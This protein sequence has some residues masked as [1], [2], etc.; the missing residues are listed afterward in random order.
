M[1][2]TVALAVALGVVLGGCTVEPPD[3]DPTA[4][5]EARLDELR[6]DPFVDPGD[7][8]LAGPQLGSNG[9]Y[10]GG[11]ARARRTAQEPM[12]EVVTAELAAAAQAGWSPY[13]A[14]CDDDV[15]DSVGAGKVTV[16][17]VRELAD[18]ALADGWL[19]VSGD[20]AGASVLLDA[21]VPHH[22]H[23]QQDRPADVDPMALACLGGAPGTTV[24]GEPVDLTSDP[25]GGA[26]EF[27]L[28]P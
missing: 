22:S 16:L 10:S 19:R 6:A 28:R 5:D 25:K 9:L 15:A 21:T 11:D 17:L 13:F 23:P 12:P 18:G 2:P 1:A 20:A 24:L 14:A 8:T 3:G 4:V 26:R 7:V 27:N